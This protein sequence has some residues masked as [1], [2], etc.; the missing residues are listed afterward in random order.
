MH[1]PPYGPSETNDMKCLLVA[2]DIRHQNCYWILQSVFHI[3]EPTEML[4]VIDIV[5]EICKSLESPSKVILQLHS[6]HCTPL[7]QVT[8]GLD[9]WSQVVH[10]LLD[11]QFD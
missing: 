9:L 4:V 11:R 3:I 8:K 6:W 7:G 2:L 5:C 1:S 10:Y